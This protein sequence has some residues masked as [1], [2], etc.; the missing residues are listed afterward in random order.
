MPRHIGIP[1][2][3]NRYGVTYVRPA[4]AQVSRID[5]LSLGIE[6]R[7][8]H[9]LAAECRVLRRLDRVYRRKILRICVADNVSVATGVGSQTIQGGLVG[10]VPAAEIGGINQR[11]IAG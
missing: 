9:I 5:R 1:I 4:A 8:Y 10:I 6:L 7:N 2:A 11:S 3:I